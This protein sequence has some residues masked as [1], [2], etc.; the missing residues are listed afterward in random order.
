M[1]R[2]KE[3]L[4]KNWLFY[5]GEVGPIPKTGAKSGMLCGYTNALEGEKHEPFAGARGA[6]EQFSRIFP[7]GESETGEIDPSDVPIIGKYMKMGCDLSLWKTVNL[8]H[9]FR[10]TMGFEDDPDLNTQ[11]YI[12]NGIAYYRKTFQLPKSDEGRRIVVEFDGV[13][14]NASVWFNGCFLGDH[15]SGYCGFQ[16]DLTA[17]AKY[18]DDEGDNV[19]LVRCD[20]T[21]GDEGWWYEGG[22]IYRHVWLTKYHHVHV[23]RWGVFLHSEVEGDRADVTIETTVCNETEKEAEFSVKTTLFDPVGDVAATAESVGKAEAFTS[24]VLKQAA[25]VESAAL[26]SVEAPNLYVAKTE[27]SLAGQVV[28]TYETTFG[29]RSAVYTAQGLLLNGKPVPLYGAC[30]HQDFAGVGAALPDAVQNYK[31]RRLKDMGC[32]AYRSSHNAA[33]IE[34]LDACDRQGMLVLDENRLMETSPHRLEDLKELILR[35][36][37]HPSVFAWSLSNEELFSGSY[38]ALRILDVLLPY[39]KKLDPTR[40]FVAAEAFIPVESVGIYGEKY[41]IFGMNY[42]E[43]HMFGDKFKQIKARYPDMLIMSAENVSHFMTRGAYEDDKLRGHCSSYGTRYAMMGGEG[44]PNAGGT[45]TPQ[46]TW[47]FYKD[48]PETGGF[49]IWTGFDYRGEPT[50]LREYQVGA[51]FGAM[52]YC[53]F[54]KESYYYYQSVFTAEPMVHIMP[55]WT[56]GNTGEEKDVRLFT[57]CDEV[58]LFLNGKSLGRKAMDGDWVPYTVAFEPGELRAVGYRDGEK[59]AED[60]QTTAGI[61]AQIVLEA[62]RSELKADGADVAFVTVSVR[63]SRGVVVPFAENTLSFSVEGSGALLGLGN[64]DPGSREDDKCGA[65]RAFG[66]LC[67]ALVQ[68]GETAGE[69]VLKAAGAGLEAGTLKLKVVD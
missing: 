65:R 32:N 11:G 13:M 61:P 46:N 25:T 19:L 7:R 41:D 45:S 26:W 55:H 49:F 4:D 69:M 27:I 48:N 44:G 22:G 35:G 33:T 36:R 6:I 3:C 17:L 64:G 29:I 8:P 21:M 60:K 16:Y 52:D 58:E 10:L 24:V 62:D 59:A 68:A 66:G 9:D 2:T 34:L 47:H 53:G 43:A 23:D 50:P 5:L 42:A 30:V 63:D 39:A 54:P 28:D 37:N 51:N 57:N 40:P 12:P 15:Y 18:G 14:R 20:T 1:M 31:I 38:Q 67:M 56:W